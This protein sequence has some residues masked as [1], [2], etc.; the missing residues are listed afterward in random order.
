M[1]NSLKVSPYVINFHAATLPLTEPRKT[2]IFPINHHL[3]T[4]IEFYKDSVT[5]KLTQT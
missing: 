1:K 3:E 2:S 5:E 4:F